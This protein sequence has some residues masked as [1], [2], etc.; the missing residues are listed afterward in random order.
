MLKTNKSY[1][2]RSGQG[3]VRVTLRGDTGMYS[4]DLDGVPVNWTP[5]GRFSLSGLEADQDLV[6]EYVP[7]ERTARVGY[8]YTVAGRPNLILKCLYAA[9]SIAIFAASDSS[10]NNGAVYATSHS[11]I[12]LPGTWRESVDQNIEFP[13]TNRAPGLIPQPPAVEQ[14]EGDW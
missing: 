13:R 1:M 8:Y 3:P 7:P 12:E 10:R 4:G 5:T 14:E 6:T 9:P 11:N 2:T